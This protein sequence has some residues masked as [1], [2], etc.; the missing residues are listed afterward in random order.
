MVP[1]NDLDRTRSLLD[2]VRRCQLIP[3]ADRLK[4]EADLWFRCGHV[5]LMEKMRGVRKGNSIY[6]ESYPN[7]IFTIGETKRPGKYRSKELWR[8]GFW[9]IAKYD[10]VIPFELEQALHAHY[11]DFRIRR[12][13]RRKG[14]K[15]NLPDE[16]FR[17]PPEEIERFKEVVAKI[18]RWVLVAAEARLALEVMR[19][20]AALSRVQS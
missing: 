7:G 14:Q 13:E 11:D 1:L 5:Y 16:L 6:L 18:E 10:T 12:Q 4:P 9:S 17:L 19:M 15:K 2:Y 20:E 3:E 8:E